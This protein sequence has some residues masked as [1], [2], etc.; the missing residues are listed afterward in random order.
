MS[1]GTPTT[2]LPKKVL[3]IGAYGTF[4]LRITRW[5]AADPAIKVIIAGRSH[6]KCEKLARELQSSPNLPLYHAL[7]AHSGLAAVLERLKPEIVIHTSGP[8]Q[9]QSYDVAEACIA[10]GCHYIDLADGRTFV[11]DITKLDAAA[12]AKNVTVIS[13]AS[14][15]PC[16]T[17]AVIDHYVPKFRSITG[18]DYGIATS[19]NADV[20]VATTAGVL[21]YAGKPFTTL[22]DGHM[23]VV[24]GWQGLTAHNYPDIGMRL[25]GNCDVP[26]LALFPERYK[27]LRDVKFTA[28]VEVY[29]LHLG[30][31]LASWLVR[32]GR[33]KNL[34]DYAGK[35]MHY[36]TYFKPLGTKQSGFHMRLSGYSHE[37]LE[38]RVTFYIIAGSNDGVYIPVAAAVLCAQQLANGGITR[39]GA[40]PCLDVI[41][42]QQY[43]T[44]LAD[45][46]IRSMEE[47][48]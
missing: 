17:A 19:I 15:V 45:K 1:P 27:G 30:V 14:S 47:E 6:E 43:L 34:G 2:P 42:L 40:F 33:L 23:Q 8:F 13:G 16:L 46:D 28:G 10:A 29:A 44:A 20:G 32:W 41:T 9:G 21:S 35:L 3:I 25:M 31:W 39:R 26:D 4:G 22:K 12:K 36:A 11:S 48:G 37:G 24:Y 5:L 18:L 7:D 38:K